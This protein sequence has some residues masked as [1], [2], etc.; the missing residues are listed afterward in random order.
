M[1]AS[2]DPAGL[3]APAPPPPASP[4]LSLAQ[5]AWRWFRRGWAEVC[6]PERENRE[7]AG[8]GGEGREGQRPII[9]LRACFT[10]NEPCLLPVTKM[11]PD[12]GA[13]PAREP[14]KIRQGAGPEVTAPWALLPPPG[15]PEQDG[16]E[17]GLLAGVP[18]PVTRGSRDSVSVIRL[19]RRPGSFARGDLRA[20]RDGAGSRAPGAL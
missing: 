17:C 10:H 8:V 1:S 4:Q 12:A 18:W 7:K 15:L 20:A 19:G 13:L 3:A 9:P 2:E 16:V 5:R 11:A 14:N 6:Q